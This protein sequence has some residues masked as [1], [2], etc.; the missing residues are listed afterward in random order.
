MS[1]S[2]YIQWQILYLDHLRLPGALNADLTPR[3]AYYTSKI[4]RNCIHEDERRLET[5]HT[6]YGKC[7]FIEHIV[8]PLHSSYYQYC[9]NTSQHKLQLSMLRFLLQQQ[10]F[11]L[12]HILQPLNTSLQSMFLT[13][14]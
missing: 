10:H 6:Q 1:T 2:W 12:Q 5:G 14:S 9:Y 7:E 3:Y 4:I 11:R 13:F 8:V